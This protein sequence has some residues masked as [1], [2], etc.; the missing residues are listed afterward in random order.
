MTVQEYRDVTKDVTTTASAVEEALDEAVDLL[1]GDGGLGRLLRSQERTEVLECWYI[2]GIGYVY[3][4]AT[5]ITAVPPS[6][7]YSIDVG[8]R[9]LRGVVSDTT[10]LFDL[11]VV[12]G[13]PVMSFFGDEAQRPSYVTV[14]YTG[15]FTHNTIPRSLA[16][17]IARI[18]RGL[19]TMSPQ[20]LATVGAT[21]VRVGDVAV[22]YPEFTGALD[23][24][25]PGISLTLR[26]FQRRRVRFG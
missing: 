20:R 11:P 15:G 21:A 16:R 18:A 17:A 7:T 14:V 10:A 25:V 9:R 3:P 6:A 24:L 5:P 26:G 23:E 8:G 13:G 12:A 19:I 2:D 4:L 1:E 22:T